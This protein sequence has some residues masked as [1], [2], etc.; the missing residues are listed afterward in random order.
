MKKS[1]EYPVFVECSGSDQTA[2]PFPSLSLNGVHAA[3]KPG[4]VKQDS[5]GDLKL[6][7]ILLRYKE[8]LLIFKLRSPS[9]SR[10]RVNAPQKR[11]KLTGTAH[12]RFSCGVKIPCV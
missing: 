6:P 7:C 3:I 1:E 12:P 2:H 5:N 11:L 9:L 8:Q 4:K 10:D